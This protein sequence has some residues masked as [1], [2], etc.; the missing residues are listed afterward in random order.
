[1]TLD[2]VA[3]KSSAGRNRSLQ[4]DRS[5]RGEGAQ[6]GPG[7]RLADDVGGELP[8]LRARHR[9]A[10]TAHGDRAAWRDRGGDKRA[11][12]CQPGRIGK[13][14]K[15]GDLAEFLNDSREHLRLSSN[16]THFQAPGARTEALSRPAHREDARRARAASHPDFHRR[17]RSFTGST[18]RW[19]RPGR[20]LS[21][22]VRSYTDPGA[23]FTAET[24]MSRPVF[25]VR[26]D[27]A[28]AAQ[29]RAAWLGRTTQHPW[30]G[31]PHRARQ[32]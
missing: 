1:M 24:S 10:D 6:A 31:G 29:T 25:L 23:R 14:V 13:Q 17:Y 16:L 8:V 15:P 12:Y 27:G 22:P 3:V 21:P 26:C 11:M 18:G 32:R 9:H 2:Y 28:T 5:A 19:P 20:G 7:Q 30:R 4:V